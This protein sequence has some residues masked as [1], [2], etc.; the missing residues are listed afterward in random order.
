MPYVVLDFSPEALE[1]ARERD[2]LYV[3]GSGTED[4]DLAAAGLERATRA[5][6][7]VRLRRGQPLHHALG[8]HARPDLMIVARASDEDAAK[9][10]RLAG[11]DRVVQPYSTAGSEMAKLV[12]QAAGGGVPRHRLDAAAAP[13]SCFEE[14]EVTA[15]CREAG[16]TIRDLRVRRQT[17]AM[18]VA[19]RKRDGTFD[20]TPEP[21]ATLDVGD[22]LIAVG[23]PEELRPLEE[24]FAP[25]EAVAA[26]AVARLATRLGGAGGR[27]GRA[28]AAERSRARRLRDERRAADSRRRQRRSP[29]ELARGARGRGG[30]AATRSSARRSPGRASSTSGST[31]GLVRRGARA[32]SGRRAGVRRRLRRAAAR[33]SRS[34]WSPRTRPGRSRSRRRGTARTATRS[35]ACSSSRATRSSASTTT[36]TP[37]RRWSASARRS[38]RSGAARSR[39]R[40]ATAATTSPS[41][42]A[43]D[44]RPGADD[45]RA[46]RGDARALPHPL[47]L[48]GAAERAGDATARVPAAP[49]HVRGGRRRLGALVRLR[50]RR[51]PRR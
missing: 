9:K 11:A 36:T 41:S 22:V 25:R 26:N 29:R 51:G 24:L 19:L 1:A 28:R 2:V 30:G 13:T 23:T 8:A 43:S 32:R 20:T 15:T 40:T 45:A 50:R 33:R 16:R 27:A 5:R 38:R 7:V 12:A 21:D 14:I 10:L 47:R 39:P 18:I 49:R 48:V 44:G 34:R 42:R 6:R 46:D 17:G 4:E 35:R 31:H 3:D 37:A